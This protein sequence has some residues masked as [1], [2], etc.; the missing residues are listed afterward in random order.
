[1]TDGAFMRMLSG[2]ALANRS[3][4]LRYV[5]LDIKPANIVSFDVGD[6]KEFW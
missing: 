3:G 6:R 4:C 2:K 1:M 5:H